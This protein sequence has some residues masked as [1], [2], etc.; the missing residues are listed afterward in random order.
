MHRKE[1]CC[2]LQ[3]ASSS[4]AGHRSFDM[5]QRVR[6]SEMVDAGRCG[7][8]SVLWLLM[9]PWVACDGRQ[10]RQVGEVDRLVV[11]RP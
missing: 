5:G 2:R 3:A 4:W 1:G 6:A 9:R 11:A 8:I 7:A 10:V